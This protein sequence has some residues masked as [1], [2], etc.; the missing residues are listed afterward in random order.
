[1]KVLLCVLIHII[2]WSGY[3]FVLYLSHHDHSFYETVLLVM[4]SYFNLLVSQRLIS[5][6]SSALQITVLL[7][8]VYVGGRAFL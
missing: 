8:I 3:S 5:N 6:K 1:M 7:T 2:M 4:F